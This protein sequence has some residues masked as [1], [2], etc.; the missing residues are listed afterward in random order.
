MA[1][2]RIPTTAVQEVRRLLRDELINELTAD[3][4][5]AAVIPAEDAIIIGSPTLLVTST[6]TWPRVVIS[7][8]FRGRQLATAL[9]PQ[10]TCYIYSAFKWTGTEEA[11]EDGLLV[12][13]YIEYILRKTYDNPPYWEDVI[14]EPMSLTTAE[15]TEVWQGG[16]ATVVFAL[17][18]IGY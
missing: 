4:A 6:D 1:T 2:T 17:P 14:I 12:A 18:T 11:Y 5:N 13:S 3:G 16:C 7:G 15:E 8:V 10:L 9:E